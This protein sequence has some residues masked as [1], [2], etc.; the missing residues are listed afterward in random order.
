MGTY[1]YDVG[2]LWLLMTGIALVDLNYLGLWS[3]EFD[4]VLTMSGANICSRVFSW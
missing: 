2:R 4:A 1:D 3:F